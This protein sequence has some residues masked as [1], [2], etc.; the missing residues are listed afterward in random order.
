MEWFGSDAIGKGRWYISNGRESDFKAKTNSHFPRLL[1][2]SWF[3]AIHFSPI[4]MLCFEIVFFKPNNRLQ[5]SGNHNLFSRFIDSY[6]NFCAAR[7]D[8]A[9]RFLLKE[10]RNFNFLRLQFFDHSVAYYIFQEIL[11]KNSSRN[12][13][14]K[15]SRNTVQKYFKRWY[16]LAVE[17][18]LEW[19]ALECVLSHHRRVFTKQ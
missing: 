17:F 4:E 18:C 16:P 19:F 9:R 5:C 7:I 6:Y 1:P 15:S 14:Q 8:D 11:C 2:P 12:T 3:E 13:V 10:C